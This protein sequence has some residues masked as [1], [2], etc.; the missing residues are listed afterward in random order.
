[1]FFIESPRLRLI[2]LTNEQLQLHIDDHSH[3][4][5]TLGLLPQDLEM[6]S[7]FQAE[8]DDAMVTYW[9]PQTSAHESDYQWFTN[10]LIVLRAENRCVGGIGLAGLP[11]EKGETEIG[12]GM[13][14][15]YRGRGIAVEA[16]NC[17]VEWAFEHPHLTAIIAHTPADLLNSQRVLEKTDFELIKEEEGR[18]LLWRKGKISAKAR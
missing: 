4:Q 2:P 9:L 16:L 6:E 1:M 8:M 18:M 12:Y 11:N 10:W 3:L 13:D 14:E 17:L 5:K 7:F 15:R